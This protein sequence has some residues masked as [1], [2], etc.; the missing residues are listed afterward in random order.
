MV[1]T[2]TVNAIDLYQILLHRPIGSRRRPA[3]GGGVRAYPGQGDI[4]GFGYVD[5]EDADELRD[6]FPEGLP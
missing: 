1:V 6:G 3:E 2:L 5:S 4:G